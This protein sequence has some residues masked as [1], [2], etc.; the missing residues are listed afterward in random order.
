MDKKEAQKLVDSYLNAF[1]NLARFMNE[2][3][4]QANTVG[5]VRSQAGRIRR[6]HRAAALY[7]K[8]GPYITNALELWKEYNEDAALYKSARADRKIYQNLVNNAINFSIQSLAASAVNRASISIARELKMR[9]LD[10]KIVMS[11]HDEIVVHCKKEIVKEVSEIMKRIMENILPL[12]VPLRTEP[13]FGLN[14]R[15]CK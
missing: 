15:Q 6:L 9:Q 3:K 1:P 12:S 5:F 8:Y 13:Q 2:S 7:R 11:V 4:K 14:F 10:A